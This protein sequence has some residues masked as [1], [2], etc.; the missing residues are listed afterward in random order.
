MLGYGRSRAPP[1][2]RSL[3]RYLSGRG[4]AIVEAG[5]RPRQERRLQGKDDGLDAIAAARP[6]LASKTLPLLRAGQQREALRLLLARRSAVDA[7][8]ERSSGCAA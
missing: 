6:A 1:L 8:A 7:P 4:E 3:A 5:R 2:W